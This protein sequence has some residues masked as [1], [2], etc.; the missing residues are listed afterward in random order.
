MMVWLSG[1]FRLQYNCIHCAIIH[2]HGVFAFIT[3]LLVAFRQKVKNAE[4]QID[5]IKVEA[6]CGEHVLIRL[7]LVTQNMSK[8]ARHLNERESRD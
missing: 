5:E 4:E 6:Y 7:H 8:D 2:K 3:H 1:R